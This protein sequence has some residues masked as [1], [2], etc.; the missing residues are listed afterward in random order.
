M[1]FNQTN[2]E[3]KD[4][5]KGIVLNNHANFEDRL[6]D[7]NTII[8]QQKEIIALLRNKLDFLEGK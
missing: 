3:F 7:K 4:N 1:V 2:N 8:A 6:K 5:S